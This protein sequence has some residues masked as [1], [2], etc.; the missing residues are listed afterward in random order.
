MEQ[1]DF[2]RITRLE[3]Q[4]ESLSDGVSRIETKLD[5]YTANFIPRTEAEIRFQN[6]EKDLNEVKSNR[7]SNAAL[8]VS[9]ASVAVVFIFNL[10]NA[11]N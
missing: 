10:I 2:E 1:K 7:K 8:I 11:I 6:I 5:A 9:I 4:L 3:T